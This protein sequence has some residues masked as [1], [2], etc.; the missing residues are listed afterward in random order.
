MSAQATAVTRPPR[1]RRDGLAPRS[2]AGAQVLT[3][4]ALRRDRIMVPVWI[5]ALTA[6][7]ASGG[8]GVKAIYKTAQS[9][10]SVAASVHST[11][12]LG[13][14]YGQLHGDSLGALIAWRYLA[15][16]ALGAALLSIFL[17]VRHTRADEEAGRLELVGSTVVGRHTALTVAMAVACAANLIVGVLSAAVLTVSGLPVSGA[18]AFGLAEAGCGFAFAGVAAVAAQVSGTAR[19]ARGLAIAVVGLSFLLRGAGDSGGSHGLTWLTWLS[20]IGW[21]EL[22]RPFAAERW[23]VLGLPALALVAGLVAAFALAARRDQGA[24][25]MQPRP[26]PETAGRLLSGPAGLSWRL[27]RGSVAG[28]TAGFLGGGLA[29]GVV[30]TSIGKLVGTSA[31]V[32]KAI[33]KI[34]GQAALT[35][36]YLAACMSL[37]GLV[38]AAYAVSAVARLR[39]DEVAGRAEPLLA[40]PVSRLRW[41]GSDLLIVTAGTVVVLVAG[42]LGVGFAFGVAASDVSTQVPRLLGASLAQLPAALAVA[43]VG[44]AF[45]GLLPKWSGPAGW[46]A[47]AV[48]G[49]IGV[50][51]PALSLSQAVLDVSPFTH[52]PKLP[53]GAFSIVPLAWLSGVAVV[54]AA[55]G[56]LGLRRRDIG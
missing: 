53:G 24:G 41:G 14:L 42:G 36:A 31:A 30:T 5:Y 25:L 52:V 38:A 33:D 15:Y 54:L 51:G 44:A 43:A 1:L 56:L 7:A 17:V 27:Q 45:V 47:L 37:I 12:A 50:F 49:F 48:C 40:A 32:T 46:A 2:L 19:G 8:Y 18:I 29:I 39:S 21:A 23:W 9:R 35:N 26:G 13:F 22:V 10:A 55:A 34:G 28:W 4:L 3:R 16:A 11:P 20:P 6:I